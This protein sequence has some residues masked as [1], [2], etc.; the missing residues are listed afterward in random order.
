M[1]YYISPH[2]TLN[3]Q[4]GDTPIASLETRQ[5]KGQNQSYT[6]NQFDIPI[7]QMYSVKRSKYIILGSWM[8]RWS[9]MDRY[10]CKSVPATINHTLHPQSV[11]ETVCDVNR[12]RRV[13]GKSTWC[14]QY[15]IFSTYACRQAPLIQYINTDGECPLVCLPVRTPWKGIRFRPM[16]GGGWVF[17][18]L[19]FA[20]ACLPASS[21]AS[22]NH[23]RES[24]D[25]FYCTQTF[26]YL[27]GPFLTLALF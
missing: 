21:D 7:R 9:W 24:T 20:V 6:A 11:P 10:Y 13:G 25:S 15:G 18:P 27:L 17:E 2:F 5:R 14:R 4:T 22:V 12:T 19:W 8:D 3:W 23:A 16:H 26:R 1:Y